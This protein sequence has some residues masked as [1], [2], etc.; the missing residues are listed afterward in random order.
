MLVFRLSKGKYK[1]ELSGFGAALNGQRWNSKGTEVIYTAQSRALALSEVAVHLPLGIL[2]K[3]YHMVVIELPDNLTIHPI[4]SN[5]L[6]DGWDAVPA[7]PICQ[8]FGDDLVM[9]NEYAALKVSSVVVKGDF[10]FIINP[11]HKDFKKIKII[12]TYPFPFDPRI[13]LK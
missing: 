2:P 6:P 7:L 4:D 1:D 11:K 8:H 12:D 13:F 3:D 9:N 5:D 10:N